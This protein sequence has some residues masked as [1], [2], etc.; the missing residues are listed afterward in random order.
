MAINKLYK[1]RRIEEV[2]T[3]LNGG[4]VGGSINKAQGGGTPANLGAG[5]NGLVG[6]TLIFSSPSAA[7]ITFVTADGAGGSA[8]PGVGT[9]PDKYTLLFKDLKLQIEA[10]LA[11]VKVTL[12]PD[13]QLVITEATPANGV[14]VT[15]AG[16]A[17]QALGFDSENA[18]VGKFYKPAA[19][20]SPPVAPYWVWSYSGNDNMHNVFTFE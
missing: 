19:A 5:I 18:T 15:A 11:T 9:N 10:G 16:T 20:A 4:I 1:F 2:Q 14:A 7:T 13:Q 12:S 8:Q 6:K 3:F 17:N